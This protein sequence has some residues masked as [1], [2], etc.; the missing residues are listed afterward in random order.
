MGPPAR[1]GADVVV[2]R[3]PIGGRLVSVLDPRRLLA[4]AVQ[5]IESR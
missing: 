1:R 4:R 5:V 2:E 3:R